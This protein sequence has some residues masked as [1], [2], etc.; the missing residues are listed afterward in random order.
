MHE[1]EEAII[2]ERESRK[3]RQTEFN[4][5][6]SKIEIYVTCSLKS[7]LP[8]FRQN[9]GVVQNNNCDDLNCQ[10]ST[11]QTTCQFYGNID[12]I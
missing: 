1:R 9:T 4:A 3:K 10:K 6:W 5:W 7:Y 2:Q 12:L 11:T 8:A